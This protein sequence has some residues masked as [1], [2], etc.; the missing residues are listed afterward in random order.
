[1]NT[2]TL[3]LS[4][5]FTALTLAINLAGPKIPA[6][7][8]PFLIY[9][10]WEIPIVFTFLAL[11][12]LAGLITA[13]INTLILLVY[14]PGFLPF[15]PLYNL[16]AVLAMMLGVFVPYLISTR[17][18]KKENL[19]TF[20]RQH[21][22]IIT[23]SATALGIIFRVAVTS[24][25]NYFLLQQAP[26]VGLSYPTDAALAFLPLSILFNA[27]VALYTIPIA[28]AITVAVSSKIKIN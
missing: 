6:P 22:K 15:G 5:I 1:M 7:Y 16:F 23:I 4:I 18:C 14:F 13:G 25:T 27:T 12:L 2:K 11:G 3:A 19:S 20:L 28:I 24:A 9:Q 8:A 10:L 26:P 17:G 21:I